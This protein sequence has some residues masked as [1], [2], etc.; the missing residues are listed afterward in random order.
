MIYYKDN[1]KI[2]TWMIQNTNIPDPSAMV[3]S[4]DLTR[5]LLLLLERIENPSHVLESKKSG[6]N[7]KYNHKYNNN[8]YNNNNNLWSFSLARAVAKFLVDI[9]PKKLNYENQNKYQ[10]LIYIFN[11][12]KIQQ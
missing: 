3:S 7:N 5:V 11:L 1:Q 4:F 6:Y 2:G 12:N 10:M 8:K 9:T